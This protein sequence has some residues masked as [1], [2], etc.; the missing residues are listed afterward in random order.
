MSLLGG[1][2][3]LR[4]LATARSGEAPRYMSHS[5]RHYVCWTELQSRRYG[6]SV[7]IGRCKAVR[8]KNNDLALLDI[9]LGKLQE[10]CVDETFTIGVRSPGFE[11]AEYYAIGRP[12]Y[13][14]NLRTRWLGAVV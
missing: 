2:C 12:P 3:G 14:R 5:N 1:C 13:S 6:T 4:A 7:L 10:G 8:R 11:E 9:Q